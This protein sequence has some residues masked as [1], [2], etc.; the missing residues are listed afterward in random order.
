MSKFNGFRNSLKYRFY[1]T[2]ATPPKERDYFK[3]FAIGL[4][5][6]STYVYMGYDYNNDTAP[7][8]N[9]LQAYNRRCLSYMH[10]SLESIINYVN[11]PPKKLLPQLPPQLKKDYTV[12]LELS[13]TLTH[14]VWD[15]DLGWRVAIRPGAREL[16]FM[17]NNFFEVVIFT[18]TPSH[19][20]SPV[21]DSLD[22]LQLV[23][24]R[25]YREH[26]RLEGMMFEA[27]KEHPSFINLG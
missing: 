9:I 2:T 3:T 15:K 1:T 23:I 21:I 24:Y 7:T 5:L 6:F 12:C 25:L 8:E 17:L 13:D 26:H 22:Q 4:G 10:S 18:N 14:L 27:L 11:P 16:L 20:A 19:L